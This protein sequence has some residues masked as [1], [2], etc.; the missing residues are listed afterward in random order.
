[1]SSFSQAKQ[2]GY[3]DQEILDFFA[4]KSPE[5]A[6]KIREAQEADYSSDE[7]V[8]F[9][10]SPKFAQTNIKS[11]FQ[12]PAGI[13]Q[14]GQLGARAVETA[15]G[16]PRALGEFGQ[17]LV[18]EK[19]IK[20]LAGKARIEKPVS[21]ALELTKKYAP[22]KLF[23]EK[24]QVREFGKTLFGKT[25]EPK[26]EL[27]KKT[28][29]LVE[30]FTALAFP[31]FGGP[32]KIIRPLLTSVG[33]NLAKEGVTELGGGKT[34]QDLTKIGTM[35]FGSLFNPK[36]ASKLKNDLYKEAR[37]LRPNDAMVQSKN[38]KSR[39][40]HS[41]NELQKGGSAKSKDEALKKIDEII[42]KIKEN[43]IEVKELEEFKKTINEAKA[44]LYK[45]VNLTKPGIESAKRNLNNVSSIVD[46]SLEEYG[47]S[48]P[49]W[50][51]F[52]RPANEVHGAIA[53]S[54]RISNFIEKNS[55][56]LITPGIASLF[57]IGKLTGALP[58]AIG[59][60]VAIAGLKTG[61]LIARIVKSPTLS[62]YYSNVILEAS[63]GNAKAMNDNLKKLDALL[64]R[65]KD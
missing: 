18:P 27:E 33:A 54:K 8:E 61:E 29:E 62:K 35:L 37:S 39:L 49:E 4:K 58:T 25:F 6:Q 44:A 59:A 43:N 41:K 55:G 2:Q 51:A 31:M 28:G 64:Q 63:K 36:G 5:N 45:D 15:L 38:L 24:E 40:E 20:Y 17:A 48:N 11:G 10:S 22:Y 53:Q 30:D 65:E 57:G 23:P 1:M 19:G 52:Y 46:K 13:R 9:L 34:A 16:L 14:T 50:E 56:K 12:L 47:K 32:V 42:G 21:K 60:G 26:G 7:I 3:N